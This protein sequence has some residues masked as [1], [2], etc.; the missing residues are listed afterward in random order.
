MELTLGLPCGWPGPS[1][2]NHHL[3][4]LTVCI[5][6][7]LELRAEPGLNSRQSDVELHCP[8]AEL[9]AGHTTEILVS[10]N[11]AAS[12]LTALP[13]FCPYNLAQRGEP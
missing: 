7:K 9:N 13:F 6:W 8:P 5:R 10:A 3:M 11:K 2:L 1:Y 12:L 4:P